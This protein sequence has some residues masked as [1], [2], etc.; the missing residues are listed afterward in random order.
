MH[1]MHDS[2]SPLIID[3]MLGKQ[4]R[5]PI[6]LGNTVLSVSFGQRS[7]QGVSAQVALLLLD[8]LKVTTLDLPYWP[9]ACMNAMRLARLPFVFRIV[10]VGFL[11]LSCQR[12]TG[13]VMSVLARS[14]TSGKLG[15]VP[16]L[17]AHAAPA[18]C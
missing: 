7:D 12:H 6:Q 9:M 8:F 13:H 18:T 17:P 11:S 5:A 1:C 2:S 3:H 15:D 16:T 14:L 4:G 10:K